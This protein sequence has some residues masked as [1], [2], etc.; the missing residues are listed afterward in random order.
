MARTGTA[1]LAALTL[2]GACDASVG[3]NRRATDASPPPLASTAAASAPSA[4]EPRASASAPPRPSAV[5][6]PAP[7]SVTRLDVPGDL[8]A[9]IVASADGKPPRIVFLPGI[10]SNAGAYLYGFAEAA[11]ALGG[12]IA[13][14]GDRPCGGS[15]DFHSITSD[16]VHEEPRIERALA[17]AGVESPASADIVF[18]GYSL[19]AT[20][21]ENLVKRSPE[22]YP[23]V[24]LIGSPRP[25]RLDRL[26]G[27][28]A[29]ATMSCSLD[30][31]K[32]MRDAVG[33][34]SRAG[35]SSAYF[36]MPGC[37]HGNLA[38]GDR[39]F[40]EAIAFLDESRRR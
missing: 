2:L 28:R 12:A 20:L 37:T 31:P 27:A 10:C 24:I 22:R 7:A 30:V 26:G 35:V 25:P 18:I 16:P 40:S 9:S 39:V 29:V 4:P 5:A 33:V 6:P 11:R 1:L 8:P 14:D 13:I 17:A 32:R 3:S 19:G 23:R 15:T 21:I 34:L 38:E 36:E